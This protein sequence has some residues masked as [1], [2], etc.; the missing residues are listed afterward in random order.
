MTTSSKWK[1]FP[2]NWP[3][4]REIH[5]FP[6]QR[7]V[8]Q[9]FD[10]FFDL[11]LNKGLSKQPWCWWF[12]TPSLSLW[13]QCNVYMYTN[14]INKATVILTVQLFRWVL[15]GDNYC[16]MFV[17]TNWSLTLMRSMTNSVV[18]GVLTSL[19]PILLNN[20]KMHTKV[21]SLSFFDNERP[22]LIKIFSHGR[23]R[24]LEPKCTWQYHR[25][26]IVMAKV[27]T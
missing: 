15:S 10:V 9:S 16:F 2:R 14:K 13:R 12:E 1:Y 25:A 7:P 20:F 4:V 26:D 24:A 3:F 27:L 19:C 5:R 8:T 22:K 11:R 6:T 18:I 21:L 23:L 17:A